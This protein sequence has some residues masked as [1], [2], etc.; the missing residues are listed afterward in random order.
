[1]QM[2]R[3]VKVCQWLSRSTFESVIRI[4]QRSAEAFCVCVFDPSSRLAPSEHFIC[5][6]AA[7]VILNFTFFKASDSDRGNLSLLLP[8]GRF[9]GPTS[10]DAVVLSGHLFL[11]SVLSWTPL[12]WTGQSPFCFSP[13]VTLCD[14][15]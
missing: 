2:K 5:Q 8:L 11:W 14:I 1:M 10:Q 3:I 6:L 9:L 12:A 13:R 7:K 15:K 4:D